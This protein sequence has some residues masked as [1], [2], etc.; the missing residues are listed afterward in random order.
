ML[1]PTGQ[2]GTELLR[3]LAPLGPVVAL[4]RTHGGDLQ[5]PRALVEALRALA[6]RAIVNAAAYTAVDRAQDERELA[7]QVNA[8]AVQALAELAQDL[9]AWLVH[10]SS[11]YVFDG[12][13]QR[14]WREDDA[15]APLNVYGHSKWAG[16]QAV[17]AHCR[18]HLI[19]RTSWV[20]G[21]GGSNF[22]KTMVRLAL[23]R[24]TLQVVADQV[25]APTGAALIAD[26]TAHVLKR[27]M[28]ADDSLAGVYHL[29]ASG[30]CTWHD[31]AQVAIAQARQIRPDWGW[32]LRQIEPVTSAAF[33][34]AAQRPLNSR[35]D[36]GKL[37][38]TFDLV[39]PPWQQG[40]NQMLATWL[41]L[42]A[43]QA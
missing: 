34:A 22:A 2:V 33:A 37:C 19:L 41:R 21:L 5:Q 35:L 3:A 18:R 9:G 30:A 28:A 8:Q 17:V 42:G 15:A 23:E 10:Y 40:V 31:Y 24:E 39:L 11:D 38:A 13:G 6:P 27:L 36:C 29:S 14:P 16:D 12:S 4:P 25:G 26:V 32:R 1:G 20:Y 7:L 43:P